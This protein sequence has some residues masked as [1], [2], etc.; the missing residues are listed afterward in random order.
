MNKVWRRD[1]SIDIIKGIGIVLMV[2]GHCGFPFRHF[3]YLFHMAI[4]F[5]ASGY[6]YK[7]S[8]SYDIKGVAQYIKRRLSTLWF[9]YVLCTTIFTLLHNV[10]IKMNIYTDN[11]LVHEYAGGEH[12][13]IA[14]HISVTGMA[15][16]I[17]KA[18]FLHGGTPLWFIVILF[19]VSVGYI[20]I[21][22]ALNY[23]LRKSNKKVI[24]AQSI[25]SAV[26]LCIGFS[27]YLSGYDL[28][29]LN[30]VF[31]YYCLFHIGYLLRKYHISDRE[32]T[33]KIHLVILGIT[34]A[35]LLVFNQL[36]TI[37]LVDNYYVNPVYLIIVSITGWHFLYEIAFFIQKIALLTNVF[38]YLGQNTMAILILHLFSF[39]IIN[40]IGVIIFKQPICLVAAFPVLYSGAAWWVIYTFTGVLIPLLLNAVKKNVFIYFNQEKKELSCRNL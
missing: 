26:F 29:K 13:K 8:N 3:I 9:V 18:V 19:E 33:N 11:L 6:F 21:D 22:F 16:N 27:L 4:F 40:Y 10:F 5:M 23:I 14:E 20:I 12:I 30:R 36:G 32:R 28:F 1:L 25:I 35:V 7:E 24:I 31:S 17:I 2:A 15:K 38:V 37:E 34:F 39:K